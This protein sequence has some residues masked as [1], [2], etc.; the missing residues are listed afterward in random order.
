MANEQGRRINVV[1][2]EEHAAKLTELAARL[3]VQPG[4]VAR[5]LLSG[6]IDGVDAEAAT[7]TALLDAI[8]GAW[9]RTMEGLADARAGRVTPLDEL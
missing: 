5:S 7:I 1:L 2:D 4:T 8:P 6:A 9:E 3:Y